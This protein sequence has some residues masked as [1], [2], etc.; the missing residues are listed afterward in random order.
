MPS[1]VSDCRRGADPPKKVS[2]NT[3]TVLSSLQRKRK[4]YSSS[5]KGFCIIVTKRSNGEEPM[6][7][8]QISRMRS[9]C[10]S[11]AMMLSPRLRDLDHIL[12]SKGGQISNFSLTG[13]LF[14]QTSR[15]SRRSGDAKTRYRHLRHTCTSGCH[16]LCGFSER[17][18]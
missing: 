16:S 4:R 1:K 9:E 6:L 10:S 3:G 12:M 7:Q 17:D 18:M 2:G 5:G 11:A 14:V 13:L 15:R 8:R